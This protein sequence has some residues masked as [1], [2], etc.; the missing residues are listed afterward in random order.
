MLRAMRAQKGEQM[1]QLAGQGKLLGGGAP[2][3]L[4]Y[5]KYDYYIVTQ[6]S[7]SSSKEDDAL[8]SLL[9]LLEEISLKEIKQLTALV[10]HCH[11]FYGNDSDNHWHLL[12]TDHVPDTLC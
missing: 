10:G 7:L 5:L 1:A 2:H 4:W 9:A 12:G 8:V 3:G 6:I 11:H